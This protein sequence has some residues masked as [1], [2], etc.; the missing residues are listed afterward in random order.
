[1]I[2]VAEYKIKKYGKKANNWKKLY[3]DEYVHANQLT[4][5]VVDPSVA[6][7]LGKPKNSSTKQE[8]E[9]ADSEMIE[10]QI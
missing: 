4:S 9:I 5:F 2:N 8:V 10:E 1:M 6:K 3:N 7:L